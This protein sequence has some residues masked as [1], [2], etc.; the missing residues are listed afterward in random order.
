MER[1]RECGDCYACCNGNLVAKILSNDMGAGKPCTFLV[2]TKCVVYEQRPQVCKD[3]QCAWSQGLL[4]EDM[5]PTISDVMISVEK[6][7]QKQFF[8]VIELVSDI[9]EEVYTEIKEFTDKHD[10]YFI[11]VPY[12]KVIPIVKT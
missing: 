12:R 10:T 1:L 2:D 6:D 8:R 9:K 3:Y 4:S 7:G 11:K 5:K